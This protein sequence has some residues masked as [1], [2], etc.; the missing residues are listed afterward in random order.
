[1]QHFALCEINVHTGKFKCIHYKPFFL[2]ISNCYYFSPV[3]AHNGA[4]LYCVTPVVL[5]RLMDTL[6]LEPI[7][8]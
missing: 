4:G 3:F 2:M 8:S 1:M 5:Q 7:Q 6:T